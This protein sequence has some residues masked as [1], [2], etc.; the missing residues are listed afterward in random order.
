M[1]KDVI[2]KINSWKDNRITVDVI[3]KTTKKKER[4]MV[5]RVPIYVL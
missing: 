2:F 1:I 5:S 3:I 4:S